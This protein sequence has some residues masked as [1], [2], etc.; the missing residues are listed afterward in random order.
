M[1]FVDDITAFMEGRNKELPGIAEKVLTA[2]KREVEKKGLKLSITEGGEEETSK[3]IASF[4]C[5]EEKFQECGKREEVG[6]HWQH[7]E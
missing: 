2:M 1:Y 5:L 7:Q 4:S 6:P 3:V